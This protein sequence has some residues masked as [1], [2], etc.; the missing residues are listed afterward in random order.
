M[1]FVFAHFVTE[2]K[3]YLSSSEASDANSGNSD[4]SFSSPSTQLGAP[5]R[6]RR[7]LGLTDLTSI[8]I[9]FDGH[10]NNSLNSSD[11]LN[12]RQGNAFDDMPQLEVLERRLVESGELDAQAV[13][14]RSALTVC[15]ILEQDSTF[16]YE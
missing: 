11:S 16:K 6:K 10:F 7:N 9:A 4:N 3:R 12:D 2:K 13:L 15:Q 5:P 8:Q 14:P 1:R